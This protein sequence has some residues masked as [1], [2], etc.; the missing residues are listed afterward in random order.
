MNTQ[1]LKLVVNN[2]AESSTSFI[3]ERHDVLGGKAFVVRTKQSGDMYQFHMRVS[4]ERKYYR[5]SLRTKHLQTAIAKAEDKY[6]ELSHKVNTGV[7]IFSPTVEEV[8]DA[9]LDHRELDVQNGVIVKERHSTIRTQL[10]HA[11]NMLGKTTKFSTLTKK[12]LQDYRKQRSSLGA[13]DI[14]IRNEQSSINAMCKYAYEEKLIDIPKFEFPQIKIRGASKDAIRRQT[15]TDEEYNRLCRAARSYAAKKNTEDEDERFEKELVRHFILV[16]ANSMLRVGELIQLK[17]GCVKTY[18][19]R[20]RKDDE[21]SLRLAEITVKAETS[22]VRNER[23]CSARGGE[24]FDRLKKLS[25]HTGDDDFV[26]TH[27]TGNLISERVR[28]RHFGE[29]MELAEIDDWKKR[30]I[31]YSSLR[32]YG[33]T[34]RVQA[35]VNILKLAQ[36]CGTS[37][38]HIQDTYYHA[39]LRDMEETALLPYESGDDGYLFD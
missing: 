12:S 22:K 39:S 23:I 18:D 30:K 33:I 17:W 24:Y 8:V 32:H 15:F 28:N 5:Q 2:E 36:N 19:K 13:Q 20:L 11:T 10:K 27:H 34:K 21:E 9:Y 14:T 4:E 35:G 3:T 16:G 25:N 31:H 7:R 1:N 6:V 37:P 29:L 38:K 26:F